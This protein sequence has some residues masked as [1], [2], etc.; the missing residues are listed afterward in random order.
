MVRFLFN[1]YYFSRHLWR[2]KASIKTLQ[3][4]YYVYFTYSEASVTIRNDSPSLLEK[5]HNYENKT[6]KKWYLFQSQTIKNLE[7]LPKLGDSLQFQREF[8]FPYRSYKTK[9]WESWNCFANGATSPNCNRCSL[10]SGFHKCKI[11]S[12]L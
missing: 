8:Q 4:Q 7:L 11:W 5:W 1:H 12:Y 10:S 3:K 2:D 6:I 9:N